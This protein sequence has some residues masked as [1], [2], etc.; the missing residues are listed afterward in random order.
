MCE[1]LNGLNFVKI[2]LDDILIFSN[3]F[4][5]HNIHL[6]E[7]LNCLWISKFKINFNKSGFFK[8]KILYLG[9]I[10]YLGFIKPDITKLVNLKKFGIPKNKRQFMKII[11]S[12][13]WFGPY[14]T[15]LSNKN[16]LLSSKLANLGKFE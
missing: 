8:P 14:I 10:I 15:N 13:Q 11:G 1:L 9:Q 7:V 5:E 6:L 3:S 16:D 4:L 12:I 2:F